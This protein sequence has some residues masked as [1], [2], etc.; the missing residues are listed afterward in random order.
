MAR[1]HDGQSIRMGQGQDPDG[2]LRPVQLVEARGGARVRFQIVVRQ[3][4]SLGRP[5]GARGV[6]NDGEVPRASRHRLEGIRLARDL[7]GEGAHGPLPAAIHEEHVL[8]AREPPHLLLDFPDH[9]RGGDDDLGLGVGED[10]RD[11]L[12]AEQED[13]RHDDAA[14]AQDA[15]VALDDLG[16]VRQ[17]DHHAIARADPEATEGVGHATG[18]AVLVHVRQPPPLEGKRFVLAEASDALVA[19]PG[20]GHGVFGQISRRAT[21][22]AP[23]VGW[24]LSQCDHIGARRSRSRRSMRVITLVQP[25]PGLPGSLSRSSTA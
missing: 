14:R 22:R 24:V 15:A 7:L 9:V 6:E 10:M 13:H 18:R 23:G 21:R 11:L 8:Q 1:V 16:T 4:H 12:L 20:Q 2:P 5:R 25:R 17:H 19:E 3:G